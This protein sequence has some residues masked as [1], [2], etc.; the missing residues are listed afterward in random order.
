MIRTVPE[1]QIVD[2]LLAEAVRIAEEMGV[3]VEA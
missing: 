1:S 2:T 3:D